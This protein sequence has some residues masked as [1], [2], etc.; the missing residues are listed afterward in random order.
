L[1]GAKKLALAAG[2]LYIA[3]CGRSP[4]EVE[5]PDNEKNSRNYNVSMLAGN[6]VTHD[7][8]VWPAKHTALSSPFGPRQTGSEGFN[9]DFHKGLDIPLPKEGPNGV[10]AVA[11]GKVYSIHTE[12]EKESPYPSGGNVIVLEHQADVGFRFH[13]KSYKTYYSIYMHLGSTSVKKDQELKAGESIGTMGHSGT[14]DFDHLHFEIRI[15]TPC[16]KTWQKSH[17]E[18]S[19]SKFFGSES[20]D[21][22]PSSRCAPGKSTENKYQ[23]QS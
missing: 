3:S 21:P 7:H 23:T 22:Q 16:S 8:T 12:N 6:K 19:C 18:D 11:D 14:A 4:F 10:I 2:I 5:Q 13:G 17:P 1:D 15:G 9:Y 20:V